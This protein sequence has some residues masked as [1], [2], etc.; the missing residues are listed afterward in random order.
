MPT[1][2]SWEEETQA[3]FRVSRLGVRGEPLGE[4]KK[5]NKGETAMD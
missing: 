1:A 3:G 5:V 2:N 4:E